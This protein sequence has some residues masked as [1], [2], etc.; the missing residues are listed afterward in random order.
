MQSKIK[1]Q[2]NNSDIRN[3]KGVTFIEMLLYMAVMSLVLV[4]MVRF[5]I[6][7]H[8]A[9]AKN[10][11]S[12]QVHDNLRVT[13]YYLKTRIVMSDSLDVGGS[14]LDSDP[15]MLYLNTNDPLTHPII[16]ALNVDDGQVFISEGLSWPLPITS[17]DIFMTKFQF[18]KVNSRDKDSLLIELEA[19]AIGDTKEHRYSQSLE[20]AVSIRHNL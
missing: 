11:I 18:S 4:A 9:Y 8:E 19:T 17:N 6:N 16:F 2:L 10:Y 1:T 15:G 13:M 14:I 5:S 12:Q 20:S 7:I 3:Q